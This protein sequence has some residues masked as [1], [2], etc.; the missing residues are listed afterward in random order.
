MRIAIVTH[1]GLPEGS[2]DDQALANAL[3]VRQV[4]VRFA[5]WDDP[6]VDWGGVDLAVIRSSWDYHLA[7]ARWFA[8]L[9]LV[10]A[11]TTLVNPLALVRWNSDKRYLFDLA[12]Q[13]VP[14]VPTVL[15]GQEVDV[16]EL[17]A[18]R[19][20]DDIVIKPTIGASADGARR[21]TGPGIAS[22]AAA[23]LAALL[24]RGPALLQPYQPVVA[25]ARERSLVWIDGRFSHAF[26]KPGFHT[27][28]SADA[29]QPHKPATAE[30]ALAAQVLET[31]PQTPLISRVDMIPT[32][33]GLLL[34]EVE[35]IEPQLALHL[36]E[37]S[38]AALAD[39][40]SGERT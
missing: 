22:C 8:W 12:A 32:D 36:C 1:A 14:I 11:Q 17:A 34:M 18:E 13:G 35:L 28:L 4:A 24:A 20:W 29:L 25:S 39:R 19:G 9:D 23:H 27:G 37:Q 10:A 3:R 15:L 21:F 40:L 30:L 7:P 2:H 38:A 6:A 5:V 33:A 26:T 16:T 31:L